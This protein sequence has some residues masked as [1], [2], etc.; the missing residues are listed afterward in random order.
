MSWTFFFISML[1]LEG[2][3]GY[4]SPYMSY[5]FFY[6]FIYGC[7]LVLIQ[8]LDC[9]YIHLNLNKHLRKLW[10]TTSIVYKHLR[11]TMMFFGKQLKDMFTKTLAKQRLFFLIFFT[12]CVFFF[13]S[14]C[15]NLKDI[16]KYISIYNFCIF[17]IYL[18][19]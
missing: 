17:F 12:S 1:Q 19:F 15:C 3:L 18:F 8:K 4:I 16:K 9:I 10:K 2:G 14:S 13:L 7:I 11:K 6:L 5:I